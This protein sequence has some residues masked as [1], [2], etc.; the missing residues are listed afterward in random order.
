MSLV[1]AEER[2][3]EVIGE[4]VEAREDALGVWQKVKPWFDTATAKSCLV[5]MGVPGSRGQRIEKEGGRGK[6]ECRAKARGGDPD[7][8][9]PRSCGHGGGAGCSAEE[10]VGG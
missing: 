3:Q 9:R 4:A 8:F 6:G 1:G 10:N 2:L 7:R 5:G